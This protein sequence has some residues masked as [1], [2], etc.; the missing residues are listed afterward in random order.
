M[1]PL[2]LTLEKPMRQM[3]ETVRSEPYGMVRETARETVAEIENSK[4]L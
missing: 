1:S 2:G 4:K 3:I